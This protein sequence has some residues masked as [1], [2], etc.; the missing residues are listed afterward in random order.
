MK[1]E[2]EYKAWFSPEAIR[3]AVSAFDVI[4]GR[5]REGKLAFT[6]RVTENGESWTYDSEMDFFDAYGE[7]IADAKLTKKMGEYNLYL[8]YS[9]EL[10]A[11][12]I[13]VG[14]P[15]RD[16]IESIF[17]IFETEVHNDK[18]SEQVY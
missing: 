4:A 18:G 13:A 9:R 15:H 11:T 8:S 7:G 17:A 10:K 5:G 12:K 2:K 14:S 6:Y 16:E 1:K 3:K